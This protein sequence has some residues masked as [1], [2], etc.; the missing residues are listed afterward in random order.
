MDG[1]DFLH[2][3]HN[4]SS[5]TIH[6]IP[7]PTQSTQF[8]FLHNRHNSSSYTIH[9]IPLPTQATQFLF[10]HNRHNSSSYTIDTI[11]LPTQSTQLLFLH[12]P[13]NSSSY[14]IQTIPLPSSIATMLDN[15]H[16]SETSEHSYYP[17]QCIN[18]TDHYVRKAT[19]SAT[20]PKF[21]TAITA[22]FLLG[23]CPAISEHS[24]ASLT[25]TPCAS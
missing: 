22:L 7:L 8:L 5:Y 4:S 1:C 15:F 3:R 2:N 18:Q 20:I 11:P 9:T 25:Q 23:T 13:H 12:N 6:T 16:S 14:T 17:A 19:T 10:L 24:T 21:P